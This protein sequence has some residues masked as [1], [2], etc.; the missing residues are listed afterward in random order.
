MT[1]IATAPVRHWPAA[2]ASA[3]AAATGAVIDD[4]I[5]LRRH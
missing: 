4:A 5:A 1:D 3:V 2:P